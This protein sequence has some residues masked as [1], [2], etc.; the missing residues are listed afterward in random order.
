MAPNIFN[1]GSSSVQGSVKKYTI[2]GSDIS[3][4]TRKLEAAFECYGVPF[5]I[6]PKTAEIKTALEARAATHQI[7]VLLTPENWILADTTPILMMLDARFPYR[8]VFP[9]GVNGVIVH[10]L[11][12]VLDEWMART[13]VHFRWHYDENTQ[14]VISK[15][16]GE[17]VGVDEARQHQLAK[18]GLRACRATGTE[19]VV[20][21][22]YAEKEY[23]S[24]VAALEE[25]LARTPYALGGRPTA[26]DTILMGSLRGHTNYD[27]FPDMGAYSRVQAWNARNKE[28]ANS[29]STKEEISIFD[30]SSP[31]VDH[32]VTLA[33]EQYA[34]FIVGNRQALL[35]EEKAFTVETYGEEVSYLAREYPER[36]RQML[37]QRIQHQLD[38]DERRGV[39]SW[40]E[41]HG[42]Q[43]CFELT[44]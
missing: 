39:L 32:L 1:I 19:S 10:L 23:F 2:F 40:L 9:L 26:V 44:S 8:R 15:L 28:Q 35:N 20:Q 22:S 31:F 21:Q 18:W 13:M 34:P 27:P 33:K 38:E 11:E 3:L 12:E 5:E 25:Q 6:K 14:F 36:S 42:L 37:V 30:Q 24:I 43:H 17:S 4:F 29:W 16:T 41:D 7:P